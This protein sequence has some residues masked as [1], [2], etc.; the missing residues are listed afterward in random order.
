[1]VSLLYRIVGEICKMKFKKADIILCLVILVLVGVSYV[2]M[3][4]MKKDGDVVVITMDNK[5]VDVC[6]LSEDKE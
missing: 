5:E 4:A 1:M 2:L 6:S 3:T